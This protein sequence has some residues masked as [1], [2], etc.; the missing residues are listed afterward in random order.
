MLLSTLSGCDIRG[1]NKTNIEIR[2]AASSQSGSG[3]VEILFNDQWGA[4]CDVF[5]GLADAEV[6]CRDLGYSGALQATGG[7]CKFNM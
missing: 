3:R 4:I 1:R 2:L 5:W 6:A 7:G